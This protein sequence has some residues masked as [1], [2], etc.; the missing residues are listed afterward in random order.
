MHDSLRS[1]YRQHAGHRRPHPRQD[2]PSAADQGARR[3][4]RVAVMLR[5]SLISSLQDRNVLAGVIWL[6]RDVMKNPTFLPSSL[7][8]HLFFR[9]KRFSVISNRPFVPILLVF[10]S[11]LLRHGPPGAYQATIPLTTTSPRPAIT[12]MAASVLKAITTI[13]CFVC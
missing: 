10:N 4:L 12:G 5:R 1:L 3:L 11:C 2:L 9:E 7:R 13:S 8:S 6:L